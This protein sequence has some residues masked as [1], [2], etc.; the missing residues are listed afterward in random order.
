MN[1]SLHNALLDRFGMLLSGICL[2]HCLALPA[3][4]TTLSLVGGAG[5][6]ESHTH[7]W[8][9]AAALPTSLIAL[10]WGIRHHG[11]RGIGWVGLVG[12]ALLAAAWLGHLH[13]A[14][15]ATADRVITP[16]GGLLLAG[17]HAWNLKLSGR[18]ATLPR[19]C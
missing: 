16:I 10:G 18:C 15:G 13:E 14:I 1:L 4:A 8:L 5:L 9:L 7:G 17:A 2:A 6:A 12:V 19:A 3:L 11:R